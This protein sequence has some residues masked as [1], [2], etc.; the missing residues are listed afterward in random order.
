MK[1]IIIFVFLFI[2]IIVFAFTFIKVKENYGISF[3]YAD[4]NYT[5]E[6]TITSKK[7]NDVFYSAD[8]NSPSMSEPILDNIIKPIESSN[9]ITIIIDDSGNTLDYTDRYFQLAYEYGITFAVLPDSPHSIDFSYLAYSNDVNVILHMP[10]E[11][12][13]YFGEKTIIR[14]GMNKDEVFNLLDYSFSKVPY[15]NGMNNHTGSLACKDIL[16]KV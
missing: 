11:G 13:G 12:S 14:I 7:T 10:M 9:F 1:R 8:I 16:K 4:E 5:S 6:K 15:A 2:I 3:E